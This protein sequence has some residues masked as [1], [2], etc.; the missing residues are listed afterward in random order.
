VITE[1]QLIEG[2][3]DRLTDNETSKMFEDAELKRHLAESI[4]RYSTF[5]A[6]R[7]S[8]SV[9]LLAATT[10]YTLPEDC[11]MIVEL[12]DPD[13]ELMSDTLWIQDGFYLQVTNEDLVDTMASVTVRYEGAHAV[14]NGSYS[15][16]PIQTIT[17]ILDLSE[18]RCLKAMASDMAKRPMYNETQVRVDHQDASRTW[19][20]MAAALEAGVENRL[21]WMRALV[22]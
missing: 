20:R 11:L 5:R 14:A 2:L 22:G 19:I 6:T 4:R 18:A 9:T 10:H 12:R 3:R 17:D 1:V 21:S 7:N 13:G 16:L 8:T 15:T